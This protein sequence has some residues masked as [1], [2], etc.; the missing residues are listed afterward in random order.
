MKRKLIR[1]ILAT[2]YI[3]SL[4]A[5]L[6]IPSQPVSAAGVCDVIGAQ[7]FSSVVQDNDWV[8]CIYYSNEWN[9]P[10]PTGTA[11]NYF[12]IILNTTTIDYKVPQ[13]DWGY[14]PTWLYVNPT[15]AASLTWKGAYS[16]DV[17]GKASQY[18]APVPS[19]TYALQAADWIGSNLNLLDAWVRTTAQAMEVHYGA[20]FDYYTESYGGTTFPA[21]EGVLTTIGAEAFLKG[22]PGLDNLRPGLFIGG[23]S[24]T[25]YEGKT[26]GKAYENTQDWEV[27]V[28]TTI[29]G[30]TNDTG[31]LLNLSGKMIAALVTFL[32]YCGLAAA[33]FKAIPEPQTGIILALP[34]PFFGLWAG[35]IDLAAVAV[36]GAIVILLF[37]MVVWIRGS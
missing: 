3:C 37:V 14:K 28:G 11:S 8:V 9:P 29:S 10:F 12:D 31:T 18:A 24:A 20:G 35:F 4:L 34:I 15:N 23:G 19:G 5:F 7:V 22:M 1:L 17:V 16:I 32:L 2:L 6:I 21:S 36:I 26:F 30:I 27:A 13:A 25:K 33:V